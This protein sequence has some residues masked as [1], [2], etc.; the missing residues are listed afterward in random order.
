MMRSLLAIGFAM[1][2]AVGCADLRPPDYGP[3][4]PRLLKMPLSDVTARIGPATS[5]QDVAGERWY[6]WERKHAANYDVASWTDQSCRLS[7]RV[8][9]GRVD[10]ARIEGNRG[11]CTPLLRPLVDGPLP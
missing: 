9:E 7:L 2:A 3:V 11:G 5:Q 8:S 10:G 1:L 4:E 6:V